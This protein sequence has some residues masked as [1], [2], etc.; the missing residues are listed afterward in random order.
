MYGKRQFL[1][2]FNSI[3]VVVNEKKDGGGRVV[4]MCNILYTNIILN[5]LQFAGIFLQPHHSLYS[6]ALTPCQINTQ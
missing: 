2:S 5:L 6:I 4:G 3:Q 1:D